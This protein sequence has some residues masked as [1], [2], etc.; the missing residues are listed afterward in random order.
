MLFFILK[1]CHKNPTIWQCHLN[2]FP[3]LAST[4]VKLYRALIEVKWFGKW[5]ETLPEWI[6]MYLNVRIYRSDKSGCLWRG[7]VAAARSGPKR[8]RNGAETEQSG[9]PRCVFGAVFHLLWTSLGTNQYC[10][11][12]E[13][14]H[15]L[16]FDISFGFH[17]RE[18][19]DRSWLCVFYAHFTHILLTFYP[20]FF[21]YIHRPIPWNLRANH[22]HW[23]SKV[24]A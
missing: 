1:T 2:M 5:R 21:S 3:P 23:S 17:C 11:A 8:G 15:S 22:D 20:T 14:N 19:Q 12:R 6:R 16:S 7:H 24:K 9:N 4:L 13:G 10:R 18:L